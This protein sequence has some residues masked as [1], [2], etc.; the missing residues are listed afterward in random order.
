[1]QKTPCRSGLITA[2]L[3][4]TATGVVFH[5]PLIF[6]EEVIAKNGQW[7]HSL[8][9]ANEN[10]IEDALTETYTEVLA[11][12]TKQKMKSAT[13]LAPRPRH[14]AAG[15]MHTPCPALWAGR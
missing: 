5:G 3:E 8:D 15:S 1:M 2:S 4:I 10:A 12:R 13:P 6:D 7:A 9:P 14:S 11:H